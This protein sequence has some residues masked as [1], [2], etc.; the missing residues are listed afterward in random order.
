MIEGLDVSRETLDKLKHFESLVIKWTSKIN[1]I[2]KGTVD[3]V[4]DR[5]ILDSVQIWETAPENWLHWVDIGSGGGFPAIPIACIASEK[6]RDGRFTLI[7]SDQRKGAFLRTAAR[8]LDL[9]VKV[10][11]DRIEKADPQNADV[12]SARALASLT[13]LLGFAERHLSPA[14]ICLFQKGKNA[15]QEI[16][17]AK[18]DWVFDYNSTPSITDPEASLISIKGFKRV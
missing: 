8:E 7:E 3:D 4:W 18:T 6:V 11:S 13:D 2:A 10:I 14:G 1:L 9:N 17:D 12:L 15:N 16:S 5:H